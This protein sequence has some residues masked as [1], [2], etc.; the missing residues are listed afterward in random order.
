MVYLCDTPFTGVNFINI[1]AQLLV[2]ISSTFKHSFYAPRS[3]K[4]KNSVKWSESFCTFG[5]CTCK[6]WI[7]NFGKIDPWTQKH[8]KNVRSVKI[9]F[10]IQ[11]SNLLFQTVN[12]VIVIFLAPVATLLFH[13]FHSTLKQIFW[14]TYTRRSQTCLK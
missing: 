3:Q 6:V 7:W 2:S 12:A 5:I 4:R 13:I 14:G 1:Y 11:F 9:L 10:S 8:L